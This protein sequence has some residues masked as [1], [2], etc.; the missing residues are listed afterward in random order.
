MKKINFTM[1]GSGLTGGSFNIIEPAQRLAERGYD[2]SVSTI[3]KP[4]DLNW[5]KTRKKPVFREIY[6]PIVGKFAYKVYRRLLKGTLLHPFPEV[7]MRDLLSVI[8]DCD[9]NIATSDK[10]VPVVHRSGKGR[11]MYYIQHYDSYFVKNSLANK[12]HDESYFLPLEKLAVSSW[13]KD[14]VQERLLVEVKGV[15]NAGIDEKFFYPRLKSRNSKKR[16]VSLGRKVAWK[17]FAELEQAVR[18]LRKKRNDFEWVVY[19]SHNTPESKPDAPFTLVKSPYGKDLAELYS[20]CDIAVNPSWHE[21]FAQ[22]ALEAMAC[23]CAVIT[24]KIGAEDFAEP[25]ENCLLVEPKNPVQIEEAINKLLDD[26]N[27]REN[28]A[29]RGINKAKEFYWDKI[30]DK[31]ESFLN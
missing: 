4:S 17:G 28:L 24:T 8:P 26:N 23:G 11:Q 21:G 22:P 25:G 2:V 16:I 10:T 19:S 13:L 30:I 15:I 20:S 27:L 6:S 31:W 1:F 3:G 29:G 9:V 5:F 14:I 18:S 12:I 7:E